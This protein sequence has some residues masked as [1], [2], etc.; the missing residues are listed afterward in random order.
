MI[1][2]THH[3]GG[4]GIGNVA[5]LR[6]RHQVSN[7]RQAALEGLAKAKL[8]SEMGIPQYILASTKS[9]ESRVVESARFQ[10]THGE[11]IREAYHASP[12]VLSAAMSS[13]FMWAANSTT[14]SPAVDAQDNRY[15]F[16]PANLISSLHRA[17]EAS[18]RRSDLQKMFAD[19]DSFYIHE[20]LPCIHPLRDEGAANH[21]RYRILLARSA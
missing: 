11:Q 2:P 10:G 3:Y 4:L 5:S 20:P 17:S 15:H 13:A 12:E 21:M 9:T 16:T 8:I 7:P 1:G 19:R 18:E 6:H 14:V